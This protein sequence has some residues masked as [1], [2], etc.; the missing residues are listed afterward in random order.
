MISL[1]SL[2][3]LAVAIASP[4]YRNEQVPLG[5]LEDRITTVPGYDVDLNAQRLVQMEGQ[6]PVWMTELEKVS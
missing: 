3:F 4:S 1:I 2:A 5:G 6:E